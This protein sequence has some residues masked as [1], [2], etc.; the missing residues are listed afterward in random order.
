MT[1]PRGGRSVDPAS[2]LTRSPAFRAMAPPP[3][4]S[5]LTVIPRRRGEWEGRGDPAGK[6]ARPEERPLGT[7]GPLRGFPA[8]A[9]LA[10]RAGFE[11]AAYSLG[12][13]C[14]PLTRA[15]LWLVRASISLHNPAFAIRRPSKT[16][17]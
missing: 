1:P 17:N 4:L 7:E 3:S 14:G 5:P 16:P 8:L 2:I 11:P 6:A 13:I 9:C 12:G 10:P 15:R